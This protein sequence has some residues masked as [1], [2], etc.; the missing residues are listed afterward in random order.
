MRLSFDG[1]LLRFAAVF[2]AVLLAAWLYIL[3][4]PMAF[5]PGGYPAWVARS[6]MLRE[7]QLGRIAFF[8]DSRLE[9]GV[10]PALLP[11][12]AVNF[13][14]AAGTALEVHSAVRRALSCPEPPKQV[15]ISLVADHFGPMDRFFWINDLLY[16][17]ISPA[18]LLEAE[19]LASA[20]DD[21]RSF[22]VARTPDGLSGRVRNWLYA[23]RF[24]SLYFSS[25]SQG[26]LFG[27]L[28]ANR[29]RLAEVRR[30]RGFSE[31]QGEQAGAVPPEPGFA[32]VPMQ[33]ALFERTLAMLQDKGVEILLLTMP[34]AGPDGGGDAS[35]AAWLRDT[36]SR[37][38]GVRLVT[39]TIPGWP[40]RMF[41]DGA[42]MTGAGARLFS[43]KLAACVVDGLLRPGCDL[44]WRETDV[45][46]TAAPGRPVRLS[47]TEE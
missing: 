1:Y 5:L 21:T 2:C 25:L 40:A 26:R 38:P 36:A 10:V 16:G 27:R 39:Q 9:A 6:D 11:V 14:L 19:R 13:G 47:G 46:E 15:V 32:P 45:S 12:D 43:T 28:S 37:F 22:T 34:V 23:V 17:F 29:A 3:A 31:Y 44:T 4:F 42:H 24:P 41:A 18:E 30:S 8:G 7:C 35:Y 33:T 20:L